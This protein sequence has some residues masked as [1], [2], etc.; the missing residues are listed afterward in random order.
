[1]FGSM[2]RTPFPTVNELLDLLMSPRQSVAIDWPGVQR[3][4][5]SVLPADYRHLV[6]RTGPLKVGD[7]LVVFS[8]ACAN[9]FVDL[10]GNLGPRLGALQVLKRS[11]GD[12]ECPYPLWFEPGGLLPWGASD[13][14]DVL[15]WATRGH[16][17]Q[18]TVVVGESRG[19]AYE[20]YPV[21]ATRFLCDFLDGR[22]QSRI[23]PDD[24][25]GTPAV[26]ALA[27]E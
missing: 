23:F 16:P 6:E 26:R 24:A 7:F 27:S 9:P 25:V 5:G 1:M 21:Q 22:I 10:L 2:E 19:P 12:R 3:A 4:I 8:P 13:N 20:E 14:G 15:F 18:W 17:D 11:C